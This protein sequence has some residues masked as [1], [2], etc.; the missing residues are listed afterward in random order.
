MAPGA[1]DPNG[2]YQYAEDDPLSPFSTFM[3]KGQGPTSLKVAA[4][5]AGINA[6]TRGILDA[7]ASATAQAGSTVIGTY[8]TVTDLSVSGVILTRNTRVRLN[9]Y[10]VFSVAG[11][12]PNGVSVQLRQGATVV[13]TAR[14]QRLGTNENNDLN[15]FGITN[16]AAGTYSFSV[17]FTL[18]AGS[19]GGTPSW[20]GDAASG[21]FT[22]EDAGSW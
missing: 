3:N 6:R 14:I 16:L 21:D 10:G 13:K 15:V 1:L 12:G 19:A 17:A 22:V 5:T 11:V 4:L 2:I 8:T 9:L 20:R 18:L 7:K